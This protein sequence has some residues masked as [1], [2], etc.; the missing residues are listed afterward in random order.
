MNITPAL[1]S[2]SVEILEMN[3]EILAITEGRTYQWKD[4]PRRVK[5]ALYNDL[6]NDLQALELLREYHSDE[7]LRIF[8]R[9][10]FGG[11]NATPDIHTNGEISGEHWDCQCTSCP[12]KGHFRSSLE[13]ENGV[14]SGR[15]IEVAKL[16]AQGYFGKEISARLHISESTINTHKRSIFDKVGVASS[17]ELT[18]WAY[19]INLI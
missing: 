12:L 5:E 14:L 3:G 4:L 8:T 13:V 19:Q 2:K 6:Q 1:T 9:C 7:R 11:F 15:E 18:K 17:V 16:I 10:K